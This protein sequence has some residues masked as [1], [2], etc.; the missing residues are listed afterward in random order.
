MEQIRKQ[1]SPGEPDER[2]KRNTNHKKDHRAVDVTQLENII[3][4]K[5]VKLVQW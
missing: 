1:N 4:K 2:K 5:K 3:M